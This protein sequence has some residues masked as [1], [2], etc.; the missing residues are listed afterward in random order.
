MDKQFKLFTLI[1][2]MMIVVAIPRIFATDNQADIDVM[3]YAEASCVTKEDNLIK[4]EKNGWVKYADV[5]FGKDG[6]ERFAAKIYSDN[7]LE[8]SHIKVY[9]DSKE[10]DEVTKVNTKVFEDQLYSYQVV[11]GDL[12]SSI[13]GVHDVYIYSESEIKLQWIKFTDIIEF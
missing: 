2:G 12:T 9:I 6:K 8:A 3:K 13:S 1:I 11:S 5:D 7:E 4:L 10:S